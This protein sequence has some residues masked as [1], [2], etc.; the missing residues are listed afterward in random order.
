MSD[1]KPNKLSFNVNVCLG[2]I[3]Q[4]LNAYLDDLSR[5]LQAIVANEI[6]KNGNGSSV[7]RLDAI[8]QVKETKREITNNMI[9]LEV[10]IDMDG[11]KGKS[12]D[13]FVRASVVLHGNMKGDS[14]TWRDARVLY[15]KPGIATYGKNV[16]DKRV[17]VPKEYKPR[18]LPVEFSQQNVI[19]D[20]IEGVSKNTEAQMHKRVDEFKD[21]VSKALNSINWSSFITVG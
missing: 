12:E 21:N 13:L 10:G 18:A 1:F 8:M 6:W 2:L 4:V 16:T 7:M 15:T 14:W 11:L 3:T 9:L 5:Q 20:I 17:H 19:G